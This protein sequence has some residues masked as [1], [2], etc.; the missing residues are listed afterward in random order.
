MQKRNNTHVIALNNEMLVT[1]PHDGQHVLSFTGLL[2]T[3]LS[4]QVVAL[5]D[6]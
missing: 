6:E 4:N 3:T 1:V 2:V 5:V